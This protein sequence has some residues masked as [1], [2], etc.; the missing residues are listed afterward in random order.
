MAIDFFFRSLAEDQ[1]ER[2]ICIIL[3]GTGTHGSLGL[4]A[5]K[6]EGGMAMVQDPATAAEYGRM[7]PAPST[8]ALADYVLPPEPDAGGT[9]SS[10]S[11]HLTFRAGHAHPRRRR[12]RRSAPQVLGPAAGAEPSSISA[13]YRRRTSAAPRIQRR[14][15]S[16]SWID[17][18]DYL[19][20]LPR[21]RRSSKQLVK[22]LLISVT[23]FFRDPEALTA[24]AR[25]GDR[26]AGRERGAD[27]ADSRVGARLRRPAR[28]PTRSPCCSWSSSRRPA[29]ACRVQVF[30]T[31]VD[32]GALEV[33]ARRHLSRQ[34]R[35]GRVAPS[36]WSDSSTGRTTHRY[37]VQQ[38]SCA[39]R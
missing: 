23:S 17:G 15:G 7:P 12:V 10:R 8:P 26:P 3:S 31:D 22:D 19:A 37:Q 32:E 29:R 13:A 36:A 38:G 35:A 16:T 20:A 21:R 18:A 9:A 5:V 25:P 1:Q 27:A 33:G 2:A 24:L 4:K 6:A 34:H 28:R 39:K 30:A 11:R 14:M